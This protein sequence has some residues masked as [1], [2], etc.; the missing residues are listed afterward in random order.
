[1]DG[2]CRKTPVG[3]CAG[4]LFAISGFF[5]TRTPR[6]HGVP[7]DLA[8]GVRQAQ[9]VQA[10]QVWNRNMRVAH[11]VDLLHRPP[12]DIIGGASGYPGLR[13]ASASAKN[14]VIAFVLSSRPA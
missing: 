8:T 3:N 13:A 10:H 12:A 9:I 6:R 4:S 1:M 2:A 7:N 11:A 5:E 14:I